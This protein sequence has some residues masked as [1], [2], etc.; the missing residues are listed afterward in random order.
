[1]SK[2]LITS[3]GGGA[4]NSTVYEILGEKIESPYI[5]KALNQAYNYDKIIFIG[6][7]GSGWKELYCFICKEK[8]KEPEQNYIDELQKLFDSEN[9]Q[10][11]CI[12]DVRKQLEPIKKV[13]NDSYN[14]SCEIIVLK[15]GLNDE[16]NKE[17]FELM[18]KI[19]DYVKDG[20]EITFDI[21]HS[22]RSL[23]F[24]ELLA[25]NYVKEAKLKKV[26]ISISYGMFDMSK[27]NGISPVVD[28]SIFITMMDLIKAA[29]EY[30]RSGT[31]VLLAELLNNNNLGL[32]LN[33]EE[34]DVLKKLGSEIISTNDLE[35]FKK[36]IKKC[37]EIVKSDCNETIKFI[38]EELNR[39]FYEVLNDDMLLCIRLANWHYEKGRYINAAVTITEAIIKYCASLIGVD[40]SNWKNKNEVSGV[41][42]KLKSSNN[43]VKDFKKC[44]ETI[45]DVR[46]TLAHADKLSK[47]KLKDFKNCI[48]DFYSLYKN[49]F[50][51]QKENKEALKSALKIIFDNF[52]KKKEDKENKK[53]K[54]K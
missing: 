7:A 50:K 35:E 3:V 44:Y 31:A 37:N 4:S 21:T 53:I 34:I 38:F 49:K 5:Y 23:A 51:D 25:V 48:N 20:D 26:K 47:D 19:N 15:Y 1:M 33:E 14:S 54:N 41:I 46:N 18:F 2:I 9:P 22:F 40:L 43:A 29:E 30:K 45:N 28:L 11:E 32:N 10:N 52:E 36:L 16:E 27:N 24:Y 39:Q 6:T 42:L 8:Q 13:F 17:N 12:E